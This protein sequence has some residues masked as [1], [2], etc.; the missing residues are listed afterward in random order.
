MCLIKRLCDGRHIQRFTKLRMSSH[1][2]YLYV[3]ANTFIGIQCVNKIHTTMERSVREKKMHGLKAKQITMQYDLDRCL[4]CF[5][6]VKMLSRCHKCV[7][8][9]HNLGQTTICP[10]LHWLLINA[11]QRLK[12]YDWI[13]CK[14]IM[15]MMLAVLK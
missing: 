8:Y 7:K 10:L 1:Y 5:C 13:L 6:N 9:M 14:H 2:L 15:K 12:C 11:N 3:Y 4:M